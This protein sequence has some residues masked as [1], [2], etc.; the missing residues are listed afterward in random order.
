MTDITL[1]KLV[2]LIASCDFLGKEIVSNW[3]ENVKN[4]PTR[5]YGLIYKTFLS[6]KNRLH[7]FYMKVELDRDKNGRYKKIINEKFVNTVKVVNADKLSKMSD[8]ILK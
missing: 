2:D 3:E 7:D 6:A 4:V 1:K 5:F 8:L